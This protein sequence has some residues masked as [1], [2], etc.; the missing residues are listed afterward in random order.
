[1]YSFSLFETPIGRC[2]IAWTM[3]GIARFC[4][5]EGNDDR[6]KGRL[7][8]GIDAVEAD[9]PPALIRQAI[10]LV[11][12]LMAGEKIS[13]AAIPLDLTGVSDFHRRVYQEISKIPP[14]QTATYGEVAARVGEPKGAQAIGQAMGRNPIPVIIPCH[15]V[16][17]AGSSLGG[18]S[19]AGGV[20]T[21]RRLLEIEGALPPEPPSLFDLLDDNSQR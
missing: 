19:G 16:L 11:R 21:K 9:T 15:R 14:G 17:A 13:F 20:D 3:Q 5:P 4:F 1:M 12:Q 7:L 18:F 10:D 6:T 2:G 8:K